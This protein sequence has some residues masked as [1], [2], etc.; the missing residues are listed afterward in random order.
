[1]ETG[2]KAKVENAGQ[3]DEYLKELQPIRDEL[4]VQLKEMLYPESMAGERL[5]DARGA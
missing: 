4:G 3:Y 5:S 1:M 2:I